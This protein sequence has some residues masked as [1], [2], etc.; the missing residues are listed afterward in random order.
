MSINHIQQSIPDDQAMNVKFKKVYCD[1][2][3]TDVVDSNIYKRQYQ[4]FTSVTTGLQQETSILD[5]TSS[6]GDFLLSEYKVGTRY[7]FSTTGDYYSSTAGNQYIL[8]IKSG[9]LVLFSQT[10]SIPYNGGG[11]SLEGSLITEQ[12]GAAGIAKLRGFIKIN[13][14]S[15]SSGSTEFIS[16]FLDTT[17]YQTEYAD[18]LNITVE[19]LDSCS[20]TYRNFK[21]DRVG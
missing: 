5:I 14:T 2:V 16:N 1:E 12:T 15:I 8:K 20:M 11:H 13:Y 19:W 4:Q 7:D 9:S 17:T 10:F 18:N 6:V 3:I 21:L